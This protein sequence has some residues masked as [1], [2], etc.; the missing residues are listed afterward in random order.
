MGLFNIAESLSRIRPDE[1]S[2]VR[3]RDVGSGEAFTT[4]ASLAFDQHTFASNERA[5]R[6]AFDEDIEGIYQ[7]TGRRLDNPYA[8][9]V[10]DLS[11]F[12]QEK[13][14]LST[15][16]KVARFYADVSRLDGVS[17]TVARS[18]EDL[19]A[20]VAQQRQAQ[21]DEAADAAARTRGVIPNVAGFAG[22]VAGTM[23]DPIV[24]GSMFLGAGA[25]TTLARA[26]LTEAAIGI[27]SEAA[28]QAQ[29]QSSRHKVLEEADL[30]EAFTSIML[31]GVGG[32]A[33]A[34]VARAVPA[35]LR[36]SRRTIVDLKQ[37]PQTPEVRGTIHK[38]EMELTAREAN[39]Y[40]SDHAG[41][42]IHEQRLDRTTEALI[43]G[44]RVDFSEE[45][46]PP[47]RPVTLE[48]SVL[49]NELTAEVLSELELRQARADVQELIQQANLEVAETNIRRVLD[50]G[51]D[52][53]V[54]QLV[55]EIR[56][57]PAEVESLQQFIARK[58][59]KTR[60]KPSLEK[61]AREA[62]AAGYPVS[63]VDE[64]EEALAKPEVV[65]TADVPK[66][67]ANAMRQQAR[68]AL[69]ARGIDPASIRDGNDLRARMSSV[70]ADT[71]VAAPIA[72][73][74]DEDF[75]IDEVEA[76]ATLQA[77]DPNER[78]TVIDDDG[79]ERTITI[80]QMLEEFQEQEAVIETIAAC[81]RRA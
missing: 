9:D 33:F 63:S 24:A 31:A 19:Q 11:E 34:G 13:K 20:R 25:G 48:R 76:M 16:E 75:E 70:P 57:E 68:Q 1:L 66:A 71:E 40:A 47:A 67:E 53:Q 58:N 77:R 4:Q 72:V 12:S 28:V 81:V 29:V 65:R 62:E 49:T 43:K 32:A 10:S 14:Q 42:R 73:L 15:E 17:D 2:S 5:I 78:L 61:T 59:L 51:S 30:N 37:K 41:I 6:D 46:A 52:D 18:Y 60:T 54:S 80:G 79:T 35:M 44:K 55:T 23:A 3:G 39:P 38:A 26:L 56:S 7:A 69:G 8:P 36:R 50:E 27:G 74:R 64:L 22:S 45:V 21:R